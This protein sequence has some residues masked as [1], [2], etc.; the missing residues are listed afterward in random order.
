MKKNREVYLLVYSQSKLI[1]SAS[2]TL[3]ER[4]ERYVGNFAI[5]IARGYRG[6]GNV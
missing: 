3:R 6:L 4:A 2:L 1:G 5:S